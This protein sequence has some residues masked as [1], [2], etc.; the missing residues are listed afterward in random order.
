[1]N[2]V[3]KGEKKMNLKLPIILGTILILILMGFAVE[4]YS[5]Q[6][7]WH[8]VSN[9]PNLDYEKSA[10]LELIGKIDGKNVYKYGLGDI[11]YQTFLD[12]KKIDVK[13]Y[14]KKSWVT[15]DVLTVSGLHFLK[16]GH[17]IYQFEEFYIIT[18]D[19]AIVLC[20]NDISFEDV[21]KALEN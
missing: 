16:R 11:S 15:E 5:A 9:F 18:T 14:L 8:G 20:S 13:D 17:D 12:A 19:N 7:N 4:V 6:W 21:M 2:S 1:M 10:S 3:R